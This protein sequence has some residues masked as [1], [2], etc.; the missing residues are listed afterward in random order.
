ME[1]NKMNVAIHALDLKDYQSDTGYIIKKHKITK[2]EY[3]EKYYDNPEVTYEWNNGEL[4]EKGVSDTVTMSMADWFYELLGYYLKT[5][6]IAT[7]T[8]LEMGFNLTL[9]QKDQVRRPDFGIVLNTN[10]IP[11]KPLDK[12]YQ[13]TFDLCIEALSNSKV[14]DIKRD[15]EDKWLEYAQGGVKEYYILDG[16]N[17]YTAFYHLNKQ[18]VYVPIKSKKGG[19]IQSIELP[20]FQF[21]ISD[22]SNRPSPEQMIDNPVYQ[23]F[24]LPG[25]SKAKQ[26]AQEAKQ[27]VQEAKQQAE[28]EKKA[29]QQAEQNVQEAKQQ[30]KSEKKARQEAEK[31]IQQTK[32]RAE[33]LAQKLRALGIE[34]DDI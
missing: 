29:R 20:G 15:T 1:T 25:Y 6:P 30:A 5:H 21:R 7:K 4:E 31:Q 11:L 23:G 32:K 14:T 33:L 13:G 8:F 17:R 26:Q 19:I 16:H 12:S 24:V 10:P 9:S 2:D 22:L 27:Q 3:W 28:A 34:P 18:G